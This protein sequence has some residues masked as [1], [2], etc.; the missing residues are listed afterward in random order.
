MKVTSLVLLFVCSALLAFAQNPYTV[1]GSITDTA[2]TYKMVNTSI[3]I[4]NQTDSTLVKYTRADAEGTFLLNNLRS[5]KFILLATYPGYADYVEEFTLDS[6]NPSKNFGPLN[7]ILKST[8]LEGVIITGKVAAIKIK[9]DTTEFNAGSYNIKPNDKVEDLL[10]QLQGIQVDKDGKITAQGASVGKVLVDGEEFF[11]DDPTLVTKNIRADMVDKVQL[12]DKKSD[13]AAFTGIDDGEKTK[14]INIKLKEDKKNGYFGKVDAS[15]GTDQ[16]YQGQAMFNKF[17]NKQRFSVYGMAGN[18]GQT[19]LGWED[20]SKYGSSANIEMTDDGMMYISSGGDDFDSF[21]GQYN[22]QGIPS[23]KTGGLHYENKWNK[24]KEGINTNYKI[25][26]IDVKGTRNNITQNN[27]PNGLINSFSDQKFDNSMFRQKLDGIYTVQLD[28]TSTLKVNVDGSLKSSKTRDNFL[29]SSIRENNTLIN[30]GIRSLSND[31]DQKAF[32]ASAFWTKKLK[33]KGR[34]LSVRTTQKISQNETDGYLNSTNEFFNVNEQRDSIQNID[35]YKTN[36]TLS[37]IFNT[38]ITYTEPISKV[39]SLVL[40]YGLDINNS[41]SDKKSFNQ[42]GAGVYD[43]LD[44]KFSNNFELDQLSNLGGASFSYNKEKSNITLGTKVTGVQFKQYDVYTDNAYKRSFAN[45]N[46]QASYRYRFSQQ[47]AI[48]ISY[49]GY[50]TQPNIDQIQPVRVNTDPLNVTLGNP[51]LDPSFQNSISFNYNS[52]KILSEQSLYFYGSYSFTSN[53]ITNN[54]VTDEAGKN[55]YQAINLDESPSNFYFN[56]STS[57]KIKKISLNVG[58]DLDI[59][60]GKSYSM[61][62]NVLNVTKSYTYGPT[63]SLSQNKDKYDFRVSFGPSYNDISSSLQTSSNNKGW[64]STGSAYFNVRL[65]GKISVSSDGNYE[66]TAKTQTFD[67]KFERFIWNASISKKFFK[68]ENLQ[69]RISGND[70]LNQ[71]AGFRRSAYNN[72]ITQDRYTTIQRY[73]MGGII[74]DFNKMGGS[75]TKK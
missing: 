47:K 31:G 19:G 16:F 59:R 10:K 7:L 25:G 53:P 71:N 11:G 68:A 5:G 69:L 50:T 73:F 22:G 3:T 74:W 43:Q 21:D 54:A 24:D 33:K 48:S 40:N 13:Q 35:Q 37:S 52:Y 27:L 62:N 57:R 61:I 49:Y 29:S 44:R 60:G 4:L 20:S 65:P 64:G 67:Q 23:A 56:L 15:V 45:W 42:S 39:L 26:L 34:T 12:Y 30:S 6:L 70:L 55:T 41:S 66:Y 32:N 9:G 75:V 18:T 8:L 63:L 38:N 17:K 58:I 1:K 36:H 28:T 51:D 2:A 46:P 72:M 14:T